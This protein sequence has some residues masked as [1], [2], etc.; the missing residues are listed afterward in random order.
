MAILKKLAS[1]IWFWIGIAFTVL[2]AILGNERARNALLVLKLGKS[3]LD[4]KVALSEEKQ[5]ELE[6]K[7]QAEEEL[8]ANLK[9]EKAKQLSPKDVENF[10]NKKS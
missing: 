7:E 10:W 5:A 1:N 6:A 3:E 2:I 8:Q 4:G 9:P